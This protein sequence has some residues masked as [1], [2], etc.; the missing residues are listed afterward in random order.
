[1]GCC[2]SC[3]IPCCQCCICDCCP[4]CNCCGCWCQDGRWHCKSDLC[5]TSGTRTEED[6]NSAETDHVENNCQI[7][8]AKRY[9]QN[10]DQ[11]VYEKTMVV[12]IVNSDHIVGTVSTASSPVSQSTSGMEPQVSDESRPPST[13]T[14]SEESITNRSETNIEGVCIEGKFHVRP[15]S[16]T[17]PKTKT[18]KMYDDN[19]ESAISSIITVKIADKKGQSA[20]KMEES[21]IKESIAPRRLAK[22]DIKEERRKIMTELSRFRRKNVKRRKLVS[23]MYTGYILL[24]HVTKR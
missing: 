11:N 3:S 8:Y 14:G 1:M 19:Q 20:K 6:T 23:T 9:E 15:K 10:V 12:E 17:P 16:P 4:F 13:V 22:I 21:S 5:I 2:H 7:R 24:R 18:K